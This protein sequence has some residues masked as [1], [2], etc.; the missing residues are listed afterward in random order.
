MHGHLIEEREAFRP[1][2]PEGLEPIDRENFIRHFRDR[3]QAESAFFG[4]HNQI[5]GDIPTLK[6]DRTE[7]NGNK[8]IQWLQ[9]QK[10]DV[11]LTYGVHKIDDH[12]IDML[13]HYSWNIHRGLSPWYRGKYHIILALLYVKAKLGRYDYSSLNV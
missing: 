11:V 6:L 8:M 9:E 5:S 13:P 10:P 2:P 12:I 3:D 4:R 1:S 7:L